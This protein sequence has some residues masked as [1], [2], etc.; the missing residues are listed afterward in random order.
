MHALS[1]H[2][3]GATI[4]ARLCLTAAVALAAPKVVISPQLFRTGRL[5]AL[6]PGNSCVLS[7]THPAPPV[8]TTLSRASPCCVLLRHA[9]AACHLA[10]IDQYF[11]HCFSERG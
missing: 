4:V 1:R 11:G 6:T 10:C 8:Q 9:V 2:A 7:L 3:L 5:A